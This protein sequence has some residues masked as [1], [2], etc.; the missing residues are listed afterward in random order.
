MSIETPWLT[1]TEASNYARCSPAHLRMALKAGSLHGSQA[2]NRGRWIV[3]RDAL[4][5]WLKGEPQN[6]PVPQV[7]RRRKTA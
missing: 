5:A 1:L 4:D 6:V 7:T 2:G 3:H